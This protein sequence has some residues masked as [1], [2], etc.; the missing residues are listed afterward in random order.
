MS[1]NFHMWRKP[2]F[3]PE[4]VS[5]LLQYTDH[6]LSV[7]NAYRAPSTDLLIADWPTGRKMM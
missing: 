2:N 1:I 6:Q 7:S 5:K 3:V 4:Q